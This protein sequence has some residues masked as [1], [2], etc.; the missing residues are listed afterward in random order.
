MFYSLQRQQNLFSPGINLSFPTAQSLVA[1]QL[2]GFLQ[3]PLNQLLET[4]PF[5][6]VR[7]QQALKAVPPDEMRV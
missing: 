7:V 5:L 2:G 6:R 1:G 3:A 4:C